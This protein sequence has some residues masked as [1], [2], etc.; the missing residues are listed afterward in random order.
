MCGIAGFWTTAPA[1][2]TTRRAAAK[3]MADALAHRG[4]DAEGFWCPDD[5]GIALAHRR[6]SILDLSPR[7]AQPMHSATG[8]YV[9]TYNGEVY[10]H[11]DLRAELGSHAPAFKGTSDTE[12]I[13]AAIEHWGLEAATSRFVGMFA[14]ALWDMQ[15]RTLSLV[16]DR[17]GIKPVVYG[18]AGHTLLFGS[19]LAALRAHPDCA[20]SMDRNAL[21]L[22]FRHNA[23]PAPYTVYE[24][25]AKQRPGTILTFRAPEAPPQETTYW[26]A[27]RIWQH[28]AQNPFSGSLDDAEDELD[29]LLS[30]A[31]S[32]RLL[33]DVPLGAFLSG[34]IDSSTVAA[35]MQKASSTPVQTFSIGFSEAAYNEAPYAAAIARHLGTAHTEAI[36]TPQDMLRAIP[37]LPRHWD[38]PFADSSQLPT[39]L[40]NRMARQHVTVC[41]S[42]DG[43]DELFNGY[44]RYFWTHRLWSFLRTIPRP[45]RAALPSLARLLPPRAWNVLGPRGQRLRWRLDGLASPNHAALYRFLV[46][47][48]KHPD[49]L[50]LGGTEPQPP[51]PPADD[52]LWRAMSLTDIEGYLHDDILTKVDRASMAVALEARV[53]ILDH[54]VAEFAARLP[55]AHKIQGGAGKHVLRRVLHRY[56]PS[57][58]VE[59]PKMGFAVPIEHWL[60]TDLRDWCES[61]LDENRLRQDGYLD[62]A[63]VRRMWTEYR[64]GE[65]NWYYYLWDVLMFQAWLDAWE[66]GT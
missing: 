62:V 16:R 28:G 33:S 53:P 32:C 24:G 25:I 4:P 37:E 19:Q 34:G 2:Q 11:L 49:R 52:D 44:S 30:N 43:G 18:L 22:Y 50:V 40:V 51:T 35:L 38:E 45:V 29:A 27:R 36:L 7:G 56:V 9:I 47:H 20:A 5:S 13:L 42:G 31:V 63:T 54:R 59:R 65:S 23:I 60:R 48:F 8:R 41:L 55:T 15:T 58:L 12:T 3:R 17:L 14:F 46:S 39:L 66:R 1:P 21:T 10:N 61:L 26:S 6:L 64:D 57:R